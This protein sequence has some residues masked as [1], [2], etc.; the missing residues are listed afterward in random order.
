MFFTHVEP[1]KEEEASPDV[2]HSKY[3]A[4]CRRCYL[5]AKDQGEEETEKLLESKYSSSSC[6]RDIYTSARTLLLFLC[7]EA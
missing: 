6:S 2:Y 7:I 4:L 5:F 3:Q 1:K